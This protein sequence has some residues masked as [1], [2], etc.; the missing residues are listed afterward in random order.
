MQYTQRLDSSV[1]IT[2]D[3][4]F[5]YESTWL[6]NYHL[7][8]IYLVYILVHTYQRVYLS[9]PVLCTTA[10]VAKEIQDLASAF[11]RKPGSE[12]EL[13]APAE[14]HTAAGF[15]LSSTCLLKLH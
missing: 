9:S 11:S 6:F 15:K 8:G 7:Y 10:K 13:L 14:L 4:L 12:N 3:L 2:T 1:H 5:L